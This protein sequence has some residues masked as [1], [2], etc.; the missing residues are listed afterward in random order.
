MQRKRKSNTGA[1]VAVPWVLHSVVLFRL[2]VGDGSF[3]CFMNVACSPDYI[4]AS[5]VR[6]ASGGELGMS[7]HVL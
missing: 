7:T 4:D 2:D 6:P 3:G 5:S 1:N